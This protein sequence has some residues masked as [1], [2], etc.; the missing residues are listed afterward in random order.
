VSGPRFMYPHEVDHQPNR[1][2]YKNELFK[3]DSEVRSPLTEV[4]GRCSVLSLKDYCSSRL[5]D[6]REDDVYVCESKY[7]SNEKL[8]RRI[9]KPVKKHSLSFVVCDDEVYFFKKPIVPTKVRCY[10]RYK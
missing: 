5:T 3:S 6:I 4:T 10:P 1:V 8:I 7:T 2:F 9:V